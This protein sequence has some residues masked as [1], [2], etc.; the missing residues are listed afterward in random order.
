MKFINYFSLQIITRTW[1]KEACEL[2]DYDCETLIPSVLDISNTSYIYREFNEIY[3][4]EEDIRND[5]D[6]NDKEKLMKINVYN[7]KDI[8]FEFERNKYEI[9][10]TDN[11]ITQNTSWFLL[12][13]KIIEIK[14]NRYK[15]NP[16]EIIRIG[17][18]TM[19]IREIIFCDKSNG[20]QALNESNASIYN[21]IKETQTMKTE[22][23]NL[24]TLDNL[25]YN[26][27]LIDKNKEKVNG[28][29]DVKIGKNEKIIKVK[30]NKK[31]DSIFEKVEKKNKICRICYLE[32][33]D[34]KNPLIQPCIC[35]GSLKYIH[36]GCLKQWI[37]TQSCIKLDKTE[38]CS[39][40]LIKPVECEL[41]KTKFPD[42]IRHKNKLYPLLDFS[43]EFNSYL[44]LE[45]LTLDKHKNKFIYVVSLEK[46][47]KIKAGRGHEANI[48]LSDISVS[49]I[50]CYMIV[51]NK[52]VFLEDN[53]SKFGTLILVQ[54][55]KL[56]IA[57]QLPLFIQVGRTFFE[58]QV[59]KKFKLFNC[60]DADEKNSVYYYYNQNEKY[61]KDNMSLVIKGDENEE[62]ED[63]FKNNNTEEIHEN[64]KYNNDSIYINHK[65][66][67]SDNE[68]LLIKHKKKTKVIKKNIFIADL[69]DEKNDKENNS[70]NKN[71]ECVNN[72]EEDESETNK[73]NQENN[74]AV[75]SMNREENENENE[76]NN[77]VE[78]SES[79]ISVSVENRENNNNDEDSTLEANL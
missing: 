12:K 56:K 13:P 51:E 34:P 47:R 21:N 8:F 35:D 77:N 23:L 20:N 72:N 10:E 75:P 19:R 52:K 7:N 32:E 70:E 36:L 43:N 58:I 73:E 31:K 37:S 61:I 33:D 55:T 53:E 30:I 44:T 46:N 5:N 24:N 39:I 2:I 62:S 18:I 66:D 71:K 60:C 26:K 29:L 3:A 17:R 50:H 14:M 11:I 38:D 69:E 79:V 42:Y 22:G 78:E 9:D 67:M 48:L 15:L 64:N 6:D 59:K 76:N 25:N 49:R 57:Q 63:Y 45:S 40:F 74:S 68:Y 4:S 54:N 41:C 28:D 27:D 65:D 16:G 1:I